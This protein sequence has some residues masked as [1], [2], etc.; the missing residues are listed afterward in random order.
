M[1]KK[2]MLLACQ[3]QSGSQYH[4]M[5]PDPLASAKPAPSLRRKPGQLCTSPALSSP[6]RPI[7][8]GY[9]ISETFSMEGR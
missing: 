4:P 7:K 6:A 8:G 5:H 2:G 9:R 1:W 3:L